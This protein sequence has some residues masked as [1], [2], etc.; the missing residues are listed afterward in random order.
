MLRSPGHTRSSFRRLGPARHSGGHCYRMLGSFDEAEDLTQET[1][2]HAWRGLGGFEGRSTFRA[3]LYRIATN[4]CLDALD[5]RA[6]RVLP[7]RLAGLRIEDDRIAEVTAFHD[8]GLF[9]A[10]GLP[11]TLSA[12]PSVR[13]ATA[14][15]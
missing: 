10:F 1:F 4:A 2:L 8:P 7:Q 15:R 6:H 5:G 14:R 11:M 13:L 12:A 3:W 9:P